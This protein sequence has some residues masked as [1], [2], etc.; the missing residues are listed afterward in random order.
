[1]GHSDEYYKSLVV[2]VTSEV[3]LLLT[4]VFQSLF[5]LCFCFS[6]PSWRDTTSFIFLRYRKSGGVSHCT[7]ILDR[8]CWSLISI[9]ICR[10]TQDLLVLYII[11]LCSRQIWLQY[12]NMWV[13]RD[14]IPVAESRLMSCIKP[15][16]A[17]STDLFSWQQ[18]WWP[19]G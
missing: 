10:N 6:L 12:T 9:E 4:D 16:I 7:T 17:H 18:C 15:S 2:G 14:C 11:Y 8:L 1:M 19:K 5:Y 13:S 3:D